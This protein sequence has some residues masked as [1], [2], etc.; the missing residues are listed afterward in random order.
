MTKVI[1]PTSAELTLAFRNFI[2]KYGRQSDPA[3]PEEG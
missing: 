3:G 1:N 2:S